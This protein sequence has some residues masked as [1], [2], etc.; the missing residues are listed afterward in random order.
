MNGATGG[1]SGDFP[2]RALAGQDFYNPTAARNEQSQGL[3]A[4][5]EHVAGAR[6]QAGNTRDQLD[7]TATELLGALLE[8]RR[9]L[10]RASG[11]PAYV[12]FHDTTLEAVARDR[13]RSRGDLLTIPGI[14]PV[15]LQ[16]HG[17]ALL[18]MV[19]QHPG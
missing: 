19:G 14:G 8:W 4:A 12:I 1:T 11:V 16:R 7:A 17:Q 3:A 6:R 18:E 2:V 13:P 5:R 10:A 9:N 15:K